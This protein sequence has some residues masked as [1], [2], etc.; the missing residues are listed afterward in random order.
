MRGRSRAT[1]NQSV[2]TGSHCRTGF[3]EAQELKVGTQGGLGVRLNSG[4]ETLG[5]R[6]NSFVRS[7]GHAS[8]RVVKDSCMLGILLEV[9]PLPQIRRRSP[10]PA[11]LERAKGREWPLRSQVLQPSW[12]HPANDQ[13][14]RVLQQDRSIGK[15][16]SQNHLQH[17]DLR[18]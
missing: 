12:L 6:H 13:G 18:R 14:C 17:R 9:H 11:A 4:V 3:R 16:R 15:S 8:H 5:Y 7:C 1:S 2:S 10:A